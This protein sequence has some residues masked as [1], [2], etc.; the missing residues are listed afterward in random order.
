MSGVTVGEIPVDE[1]VHCITVSYYLYI[2]EQVQGVSGVSVGE[3]IVDESRLAHAVVLNTSI[4]VFIYIYIYIHTH[5]YLH[6][7]IYIYI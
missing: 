7:N 3:S 2:F 1:K 4:H 6:T 5:T